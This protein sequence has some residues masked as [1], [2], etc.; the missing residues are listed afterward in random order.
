MKSR[1]TG[2]R[3]LPKFDTALWLSAGILFSLVLFAINLWSLVASWHEAFLPFQ[4]GKILGLLVGLGLGIHCI[5]MIAYH[6]R[7]RSFGQMGDK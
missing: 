4:C 3:S 2:I 5:D 6:R 7:N 1:A